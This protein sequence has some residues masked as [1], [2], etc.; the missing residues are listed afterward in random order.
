[1]NSLDLSLF[2]V[3]SSRGVT[4]GRNGKDGSE[5]RS[6]SVYR[7]FLAST[8]STIASNVPERPDVS[9][10]AVLGYN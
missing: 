9:S 6:R 10:A 1:M 8:V 5:N 4:R 2:S 7:S 3:D